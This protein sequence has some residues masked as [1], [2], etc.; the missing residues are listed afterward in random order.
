[1][2]AIRSN[3]AIRRPFS[4]FIILNLFLIFQGILKIYERFSIRK[5]KFRALIFE[6]KREKETAINNS[7][8]CYP[9]SNQFPRHKF[10]FSSGSFRTWRKYRLWNGIND[11]EVAQLRFFERFVRKFSSH[12]PSRMKFHDT[13]VSYCTN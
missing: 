6:S 4:Y 12:G 8:S 1:M 9:T 2:P 3:P 5:L 13:I 11:R 7:K 10:S